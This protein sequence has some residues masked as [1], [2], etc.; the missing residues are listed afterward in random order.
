MVQ[1]R[2]HEQDTVLI[3]RARSDPEAFGELYRRYVRGIYNYAFYRTGSGADAEDLTARTF[4]RALAGLPQ[5]E[6]RG[7]PFSAWL[8]RIAHNL[9][10]NWHR[11]RTRRK[12]VPL[13]DEA[14]GPWAVEGPEVAAEEAE[15]ERRLMAAL[16]Q[17]SEERQQL[18]ILKFV[19][20]LSNADIGKIMGRSES[21]IKSLYHRTLLGLRDELSAQ[22]KGAR[23]GR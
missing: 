2:E 20:Q 7:L 13:E 18:V 22:E 17:L 9:V 1:E 11:D 10:A 19:Q 4:Q 15:E 12:A 6:E 8:Y 21:A 23:H 5:Y 3:A 14:L 16:R